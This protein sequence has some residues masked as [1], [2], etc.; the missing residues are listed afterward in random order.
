MHAITYTAIYFYWYAKLNIKLFF[1]RYELRVRYLPKNFSDLYLRD[2]VTFF[3]LY[4]Q[5]SKCVRK[6]NNFLYHE[7]LI[8]DT[9]VLFKSG[10]DIFCADFLHIPSLMLYRLFILIL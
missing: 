2:K 7:N 1:S 4:D 5:V 6:K 10:Y 8:I 3:Y 9:G